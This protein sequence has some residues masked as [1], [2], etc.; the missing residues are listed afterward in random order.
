[1][2]ILSL[3]D[4]PAHLRGSRPRISLTFLRGRAD[5]IVCHVTVK[6]IF[7]AFFEVILYETVLAGMER[8]DR[9]SS[10]R[11]QDTRNLC[12]ETFQNLKF[13]VYI[14]PECLE[15]SLAGLLHRFLPL[16]FRNEGKC[17]LNDFLKSC[18]RLNILALSISLRSGNKLTRQ[19]MPEGKIWVG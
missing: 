15:T 16:F 10:A 4:R 11:C 13:L 14:D 5:H 8:Q 6:S 3:T 9:R 2:G 19:V 12:K 7:F 17:C 1:M 18:R